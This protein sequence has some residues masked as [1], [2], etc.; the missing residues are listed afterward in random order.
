MLQVSDAYKELVK[1]NIRPKCEPIIKVSGNDN[2]GNDIEL[3]WRAKDIK[4]LTYKR[5]IDPIGRELPYME[6][7]W[8]EIYS[9]KF[10]EENYPEKYNNIASYMGVDLSF[11]QNLNFYNTWKTLFDS[12]KT[13]GE[14]SPNSEYQQVEYIE[15]TG[16]EY[17]D[18][19]FIPNQNSSISIDFQ[20]KSQYASRGYYFGTRYNLAQSFALSFVP[21]FYLQYIYGSSLNRSFAETDDL[22][23]IVE[24]KKNKVYLDGVL[25][26]THEEQNFAAQSNLLLFACN[27]NDISGYAPLSYKLYSCKIYD[28]DILVRDFI[29]CYRK[30]DKVAGLFDAVNEKFY[31]NIGA[32]EFIIGK[33][34]NTSSGV[35]G[36]TWKKLKEEVLQETV[37]MPK[38]FL[39]ARPTISGQTITWVARDL[40]YF[41]DLYEKDA[42]AGVVEIPFFNPIYFDSDFGSAYSKE[43]KEAENK[44]IENIVNLNETYGETLDK[45]VFLDGTYKNIFLNYGKLK[46]Y[47]L[48][49][50]P[51]GSVSFKKLKI[52]ELNNEILEIPQKIMF[53]R[54]KLNSE[55]NISAYNFAYYEQKLNEEQNYEMQYTQDIGDGY[56]VFE[57]NGFGEAQE[58][59]NPN[60]Y[61]MN[62]P[63]GLEAIANTEK[64]IVTP[65]N[66]IEKTQSLQ[67]DLNGKTFEERNPFNPF[68]ISE[69]SLEINN[70]V[71]F[72]KSYFNKN[73][74]IIQC[75]TLSMLMLEPMDVSQVEL[76]IRNNTRKN[77]ILVKS[78]LTYNGSLRQKNEIHEYYEVV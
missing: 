67:T 22:R 18:T 58:K 71:E 17:V 77:S 1:S 30:S 7:T 65:I 26:D 23:H 73:N 29:P 35:F 39:T 14:I 11:T 9:G 25:K 60:V 62:S 53:N 4:D 48:Y 75:E 76:D 78:E 66:L 74:F 27:Y 70:R 51:D 28:N 24:I 32:G 49:F 59:F 36:T 68:K 43:L 55:E 10:D 69:N 61:I 44:T 72:F 54:P 37:K 46:N 16:L 56:Y 33:E 57:F 42:T 12:G 13:W 63:N 38:M 19:G 31:Q 45:R 40:L 64:I 21:Y 8:T 6:L 50:L 3:I 15:S 41:F 20:G 52:S 2:N 47:F 5:S 34:I